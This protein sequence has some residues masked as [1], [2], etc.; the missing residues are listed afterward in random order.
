MEGLLPEAP[1]LQW[2]R[3]EV[4]WS[5]SDR[6]P[7]QPPPPD[8]P[9]RT[10]TSASKI[11]PGGREGWVASQ[12]LR[13]G[14]GEETSGPSSSSPPL[15]PPSHQVPVWTVPSTRGGGWQPWNVPPLG[16]SF[17]YLGPFPPLPSLVLERE[18]GLGRAVS[19]TDFLWSPNVTSS[20]QKGTPLAGWH[21]LANPSSIPCLLSAGHFHSEP[22]FLV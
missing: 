1:G 13:N 21:L 14:E 3:P 4:H 16:S 12:T 17:P 9:P 15:L 8:F 5:S 22:S 19:L 11:I 2:E 6:T 7:S 20:G 10:L 18:G